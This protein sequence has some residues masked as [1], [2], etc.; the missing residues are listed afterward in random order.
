MI[1]RNGLFVPLTE[2]TPPRAGE[3][4]EKR[5]VCFVPLVT[6]LALARSPDA[7]TVEAIIEETAVTQ[8]TERG[9]T[10]M[11]DQTS[12]SSMRNVRRKDI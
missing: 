7:A 3:V 1:P 11:D 6:S 12:E 9:A 8:I 10:R 2:L 4:V 5:I